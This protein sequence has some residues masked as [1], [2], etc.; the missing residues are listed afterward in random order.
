[1]RIE[2]SGVSKGD[3]VG[4]VV[5]MEA[6]TR[7]LRKIRGRARHCAKE[8]AVV[9]LPSWNLKSLVRTKHDESRLQAE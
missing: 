7:T 2:R 8:D 6:S 4:C 3:I 9:Q 5:V 1:M